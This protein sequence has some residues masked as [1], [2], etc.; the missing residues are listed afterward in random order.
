MTADLGRAGSRARPTATRPS[1]PVLA[2][3][4]V[5]LWAGTIVGWGRP[6]W[7]IPAAA[8]AAAGSAV[9]A[10]RG[11]EAVRTAAL[12]A[13]AIC[14]GVAVGCAKA[15]GLERD[16]LALETQRSRQWTG[17]VASDARRVGDGTLVEV[18]LLDGPVPG[19]AVSLWWPRDIAPP[20]CGQQVGFS[21]RLAP[22]EDRLVRARALTSG[23]V[24]SGSPYR[25]TVT[26]WAPGLSGAVMR[27]RE[28]ARERIERIGGRGEPLAL[29]I[30]LGYRE[31]IRGTDL[32]RDVATTGLSHLLAVSGTHLAIVAGFCAGA[33]RAFQVRR[34]AS[35]AAVMAGSLAYTLMSGCQPSSLRALAMAG[36]AAAAAI[37]AR[38][39]D[40]LAS[41]AAAVLVL[42]SFDP[43]NAFSV[44]LRLSV[45]AVAGLVSIAP[46][47][48]EWLAVALPSR[49]RR[50]A[51]P[52]A[53][54]VT[55]QLVTL[56]LA[57]P[58]FGTLSL[59]SPIANL[60][61][62]PVTGAALA[63]G[64]A[65]LLASG[66]L[67]AP[68]N[69]LL[70]TASRV[71]GALAWGIERLARV[72]FAAIAVGGHAWLL[73]GGI[74]SACLLAWAAWPHPRTP[75]RIRTTGAACLMLAVL[76]VGMPATRTA[77]IVVLDVGQGD[78]ILVRDATH[79]VLIDTGPDRRELREALARQRV[80][81]LDAVILTHGHEDHTGGAAAL[82]GVVRVERVFVSAAG[83]EEGLV[84]AAKT[85]RARNPDTAFLAYPDVLDFGTWRL[86]V[87]SPERGTTCESENEASLVIEA[88]SGSFRALLTGDA[89]E[90]IY[91]YLMRSGELT[92]CVVVKVPHHGSSGGIDGTAWG[93]LGASVA[94]VSVGADNDFGH[95]APSTISELAGAG[96]R[97]FRT[98]HSG[99][100]VVIPGRSGMRVRTDHGPAP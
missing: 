72:P 24:A 83:D 43:T 19:A 95:P 42:L 15:D 28:R 74:G 69:A 16:G 18:R 37:G 48:E 68:G 10:I 36:V 99:D 5:G 39:A 60:I 89:E 4:A 55:A 35:I 59:V 81:A 11:A 53:V 52:L 20:A 25:A 50:I 46:L 73:A 79:A 64:L 91:R 51:G 96:V 12:I 92:S 56:P 84:R 27:L 66:P 93:I 65:G 61:A 76:W 77:E 14:A 31:G 1:I 21:G 7:L 40:P 2:W 3:I 71:L 38:R 17:A 47:A 87:L 97:T 34:G 67:S 54:C 44:G 85:I 57:I 8:A 80:R 49:V 29:G 9:V 98:D 88:S 63:G 86:R 30:L 82:A 22:A 6:E 45:A 75:G 26:G 13:L 90:P 100:V 94:V 32:E 33:C 41:L 70:W 23:V 58:L 78:A 62:V